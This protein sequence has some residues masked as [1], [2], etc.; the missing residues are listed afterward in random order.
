MSVHYMHL[1]R[2]FVM[3]YAFILWFLTARRLRTSLGMIHIQFMDCWIL[4]V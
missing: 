4:L 1:C 3:F 2:G